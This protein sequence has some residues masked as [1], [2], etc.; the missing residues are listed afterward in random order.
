MPPWLAYAPYVLSAA[1]VL[2][3]VLRLI[4]LTAMAFAVAFA[5]AW[6]TGR[7][8]SLGNHG[9]LALDASLAALATVGTFAGW[10]YDR[11]GYRE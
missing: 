10:H 3:Y 6:C 5:C 4:P 8:Y 2:A 1:A 7:D 9:L 11:G